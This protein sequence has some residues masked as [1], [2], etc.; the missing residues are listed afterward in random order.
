MGG[1]ADTADDP[2]RFASYLSEEMDLKRTLKTA[3]EAAAAD[4][5]K[6]D[7]FWLKIARI[8]ANRLKDR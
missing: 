5:G 4:G 3:R 7:E 6:H 8:L 1:D 2:S